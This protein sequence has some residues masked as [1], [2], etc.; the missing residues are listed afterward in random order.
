MRMLGRD[1]AS[2][3]VHH[4]TKGSAQSQGREPGDGYSHSYWPTLVVL[5]QVS[6]QLVLFLQTQLLESRDDARI[7][8]FHF[9]SITAGF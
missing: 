2:C 3:E 7:W 9:K 6:R 4:H 5:L 1:G 8:A